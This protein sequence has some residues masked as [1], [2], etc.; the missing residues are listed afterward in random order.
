MSW[1]ISPNCTSVLVYANSLLATFNTRLILKGRGTDNAHETVPTF[2]MVD[3]NT[4]PPL[5]QPTSADIFGVAGKVRIFP[6]L[7]PSTLLFVCALTCI[8]VFSWKCVKTLHSRPIDY[9]M[10]IPLRLVSIEKF[11]SRKTVSVGVHLI[12]FLHATNGPDIHGVFPGSPLEG[13]L[14]I[15]QLMV[16][17]RRGMTHSCHQ[18]PRFCRNFFQDSEHSRTSPYRFLFLSRMDQSHPHTPPF[19]LSLPLWYPPL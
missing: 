18:R 7:Q 13:P 5:P 9:A 17:R 15:G 6:I 19:A 11:G 10:P 4:V 14:G 16:S 3:P 8:H 2:L 12:V 1:E